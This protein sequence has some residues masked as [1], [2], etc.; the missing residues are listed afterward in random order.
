VLYQPP[1]KATTIL[2]WAGP[3]L[4]V[5][6]GAFVLLRNLRRRIQPDAPLSDDDRERARR[7]LDGDGKDDT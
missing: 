2:L 5:V 6:G 7:M 4:L 1:L 3:A